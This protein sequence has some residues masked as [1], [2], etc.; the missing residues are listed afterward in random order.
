MRAQIDVNLRDRGVG[1]RRGLVEL[2]R[3]RA[4]VDRGEH[5]RL[6]LDERLDSPRRLF[7]VRVPFVWIARIVRFDFEA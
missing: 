4:R 5:L 1:A 7:R 6:D 2:V 3:A